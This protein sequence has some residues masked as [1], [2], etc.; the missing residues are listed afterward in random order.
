[1]RRKCEF[2]MFETVGPKEA[3]AKFLIKRVRITFIFDKNRIRDWTVLYRIKGKNA[4]ERVVFPGIMPEE[5]ESTIKVTPLKRE[6]LCVKTRW[7]TCTAERTGKFVA[8]RGV[9][10]VHHGQ[11]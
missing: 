6:T 1:M 10:G 4:H 2:L 7:Y 11:F 5:D 8:E 3:Q 9:S